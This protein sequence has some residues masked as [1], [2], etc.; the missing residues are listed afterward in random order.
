ML[1]HPHLPI[2]SKC[3]LIVKP[4]ASRKLVQHLAFIIIKHGMEKH[5]PDRFGMWEAS[6]RLPLISIILIKVLLQKL[7]SFRI[8]KCPHGHYRLIN[9]A[10]Y[11]DKTSRRIMCQKKNAVD[12]VT[13]EIVQGCGVK[14][15]LIRRFSNPNG[16][17]EIHEMISAPTTSATDSK[18]TTTTKKKKSTSTTDGKTTT[19]TTKEKTASKKT[20]KKPTTKTK[21]KNTTTTKKKPPNFK[22][23]NRF[24]DIIRKVRQSKQ[25]ES[26]PKPEEEVDSIVQTLWDRVKKRFKHLK[27]TEDRLIEAMTAN[28]NHK[29]GLDW[30]DINDDLAHLAEALDDRKKEK[31][32]K[33]KDKKESETRNR[34]KTS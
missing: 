31:K 6:S 20:K 25:G 13:G 2:N 23:D 1:T 12:W 14:Y 4:E 5:G 32:K 18:T 30:D 8:Y 28:Y 24:K 15:E 27:A 9:M 29:E 19:T 34:R 7:Y 16:Y 22:N 10:E 3:E 33:K 17:W 26:Q 11:D 21:K